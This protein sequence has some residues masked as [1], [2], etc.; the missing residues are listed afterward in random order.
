MS[1]NKTKDVL[2][3]SAAAYNFEAILDIEYIRKL[4]FIKPCFLINAMYI[5]YIRS[6]CVCCRKAE[7]ERKKNSACIRNEEQHKAIVWETNSILR[8]Q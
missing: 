2:F 4:N 8:S 7:I 1:Y 5:F 6:C 3:I